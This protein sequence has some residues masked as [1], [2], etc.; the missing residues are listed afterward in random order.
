MKRVIIFL[1][2]LI[3]T[4][5]NIFHKKCCPLN[6]II[7][8][9]SDQKFSCISS[10]FNNVTDMIKNITLFDDKL[11]ACDGDMEI[12]KSADLK[13]LDGNETCVDV[14]N[15]SQF[16][17][18]QCFTKLSKSSLKFGFKK[19]CEND[20]RYDEVL[21]KCVE[22][23]KTENSS[24]FDDIFI[25]S[26][27]VPD[28]PDKV[29]VEY[30]SENSKI[31]FNNDSVKIDDR[32]ISTPFCIEET[33]NS[34]VFVKVCEPYEICLKI[35]CFRKCCN[36]LEKFYYSEESGTS[37]CV[38]HDED[39]IHPNFYAFSM[40]DDLSQQIPSTIH[41]SSE[42]NENRTKSFIYNLNFNKNEKNIESEKVESKR[43]SNKFKLLMLF[44]F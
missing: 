36:Q 17:I 2:F 9:E 30:H 24:I 13:G 29:I 8:I 43:K 16:A 22:F 37:S 34:K 7:K 32:E 41:P 21:R 44:G 20:M 14:I 40:G 11:S 19:C 3:P 38:E 31:Y 15:E 26:Y 18:V 12:I 35:P 28:C 25:E 33:I 39:F 5:A 42:L 23:E 27:G 1:S 6:E 4:F 10:D